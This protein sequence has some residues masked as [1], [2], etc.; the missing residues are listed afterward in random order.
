MIG[1]QGCG[2]LAGVGEVVGREEIFLDGGEE[3]LG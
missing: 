2:E 1:E 3:V